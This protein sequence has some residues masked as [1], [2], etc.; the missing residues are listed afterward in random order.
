MTTTPA[1]AAL[2]GEPTSFET[3]TFDLYRDI[4]KGIR[5]ELFALV[6]LAGSIDPADG[7]A[8]ADLAARVRSTVDLLIA[9]AEHE[10]TGMQPAIELHLPVLAERIV[11]D[12][13]RIE[14]RMAAL[15]ALVD[16]VAADNDGP[17]ASM[18]HLY[19]D[20]ASFTA[21]YLD[22]QDLEERVVMPALEAAV[23]VEACLAMHQAILAAIPPDEMGLSLAIM[24]P[25]MN[26]ADRTELLGAMQ[27][28][29]P[30]EAF[31]AVWGLAGSVLEPADHAALGARL[32]L[33]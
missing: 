9:H 19:L 23:G 13:E 22:H 14:G 26:L 32:G 16:A 21:D 8:R 15:V 6:E 5:Q 2:M 10:D 27:A 33:A 1:P 3:V 24:L 12:H 17:R 18:H 29:A 25:A 31:A 28:E 30:P 4:H 11:V 20:L 7:G